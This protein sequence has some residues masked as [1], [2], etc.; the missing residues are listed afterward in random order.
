MPSQAV[1]LRRVDRVGAVAPA[2]PKSGLR[3][4]KRVCRVPSQ[5]LVLALVRTFGAGYLGFILCGSSLRFC[6]AHQDSDLGPMA[7]DALDDV[8]QDG[9]DFLARRRLA[10]AQDHRHRLAGRPFIDVD[11]QE[12]ALVI[13]GVEQRE[14]L[15]AVHRIERA[16]IS[17]VIEDGVR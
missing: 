2:Q 3:Q 10:F 4:R 13:M 7:A 1:R 12:T 16:S 17:S 15:L 14:L 6:T 8:L 5:A 11:R 9:A